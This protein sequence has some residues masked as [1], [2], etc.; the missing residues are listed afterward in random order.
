M[1]PQ[2]PSGPVVLDRRGLVVRTG[3]TVTKR[4]PGT[5]PAL[6]AAR[7]E[8]AARVPA[9]LAPLG[10][11]RGELTT[12]PAARA[13]RPDVEA[14]P[15]EELG[16]L[17]AALHGADPGAL[18]AT[19]GPARAARALRRL[20][21]APAV[22]RADVS[23]VLGASCTVPD[24]TVGEAAVPGGGL[25]HGDLHL[26]Q[27]VHAGR[28]CLV[29][30]DDLG[31]GPAV[32]DLARPASWFAVGLLDVDGWTAL[33]DSYRAGGGPALPGTGDP[34]PCVDA[35]ARALVVQ[36]AAAGVVAAAE[37]DRRLEEHEEAHLAACRAMVRPGP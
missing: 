24:W 21:A 30:L 20:V 4:H 17:L 14:V 2:T 25:V 35:V 23:T 19:T 1:Q 6:L 16:A 37:D 15:W 31:T 29:D 27:L 13:L 9:L 33:V 18:P 3:T 7:L 8:V 28:W 12:W 5:D 36:Q 11:P 34:W 10:P 26:G 32:W 22:A